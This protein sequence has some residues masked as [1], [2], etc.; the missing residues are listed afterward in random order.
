MKILEVKSLTKQFGK[1]TAVDN[2]SFSL[3]EGEILGLLG[4]NG[5]GKTTTL[6]MLLGALT[7]TSGE[8]SYFGKDLIRNR[9]E[10]LEQVNFSSTY[11]DLP[12]RLTVK[13]CLTYIS[14][15]YDIAD[16]KK[17]IEKIVEIFDL[18]QLFNKH[19]YSLSAGQKTRVN[20][21]KAMLNFPKILLLDEPT[22]SLDPE[23]AQFIRMFLLEERDKFKTS[24]LITSH[25]M[26][27]VE[28]L[29]DRVIFIN[30]GKIVADDKPLH[31]A[32]SMDISHIE[33]WITSGREKL[34][35]YCREKDLKYQVD[36]RYLTID[37]SEKF[38]PGFLKDLADR[39]IDYG[40][41]SIAKPT[42]EDYFLHI[43]KSGKGQIE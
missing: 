10:I 26:A 15:L 7:L 25:N 13:E 18:S 12:Y 22:A 35:N 37:V 19:I 21:A 33:L 42:L 38:I 43:A 9:E 39:G 16:R 41:I 30:R 28:E 40:E 5:A 31:L 3:E 6:Q 14:Y 17:R 11:V 1:F 20:V 8:I 34:F 24:V 32:K 36:S 4:P 29:C 23:V 2:I 27:E